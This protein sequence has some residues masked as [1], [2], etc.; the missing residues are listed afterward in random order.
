MSYLF[1]SLLVA[2]C[3][4]LAAPSQARDFRSA[5]IHP[6]DYPTVEAVRQMGKLL[7][8]DRKSVV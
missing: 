8:E 3:M 7:S 6:T 2:V 5:D 4:A 1:R